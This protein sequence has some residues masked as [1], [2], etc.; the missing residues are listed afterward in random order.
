MG[1]PK[2]SAQVAQP[3]PTV[4]R[5]RGRPYCFFIFLWE[6]WCESMVETLKDPWYAMG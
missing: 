6:K 4:K 2:A 1:K 5:G 3:E